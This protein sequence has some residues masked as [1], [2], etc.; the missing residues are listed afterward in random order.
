MR[1]L[2]HKYVT[3]GRLIAGC[4]P[5]LGVVILSTLRFHKALKD[6]AHLYFKQKNTTYIRHKS[7]NEGEITS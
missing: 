7:P 3:I 1:Q 2:H 6:G 4:S 5:N